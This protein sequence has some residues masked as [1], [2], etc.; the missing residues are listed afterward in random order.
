MVSNGESLEYNI[1]EL[2]KIPLLT[3]RFILYIEDTNGKFAYS[4][5]LQRNQSLKNKRIP[6]YPTNNKK[7]AIALYRKLEGS[8]EIRK[9]AFI[10]DRDYDF[11]LDKDI[12]DDKRV[13]Y[14][15]K[16]TL[17]NYFITEGLWEQLLAYCLKED[18]QEVFENYSFD[19]C[20]NKLKKEYLKLVPFFLIIS[21]HNLTIQYSKN[22]HFNDY[23]KN[24]IEC[25]KN[26][27]KKTISK[28]CNSLIKNEDIKCCKNKIK[29]LIKTIQQQDKN[30]DLKTEYKFW[31][32]KIKNEDILD[33]IPGKA[34]LKIFLEYI[35]IEFH[36][37]LVGDVYQISCVKEVD[38]SI[39]EVINNL[40]NIFK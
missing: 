38:P 34:L 18:L 21:K 2:A 10:I 6:I 3:S 16:Y 9:V 22:S 13:I 32:R 37:K 20:K 17:E 29:F 30:L 27:K 7:N 25:G 26:K 5:F 19:K 39:D 1:D 24:C 35:R 14:L 8:K 33:L 31:R 36:A 11:I 12:I 23:F 28:N 40:E 15:K 4:S